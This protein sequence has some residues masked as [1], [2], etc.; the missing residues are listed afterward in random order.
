MKKSFFAI[1]LSSAL[2]VLCMG[3]RLSLQE[4][5]NIAL[6]NNL[7]IQI[8]KNDIVA[9]EMANHIG[10]AGGLPSVSITATDNQQLTS[11]NQELN[12]GQKISGNWSSGNTLNV[13]VTASQLLYNGMK[14]QTTKQ[15]LEEIEKLSREQF[16]ADVQNVVAEVMRQYY[17]VVMQQGFAKTLENS[18]STAR[19]RLE[20]VRTRKSVGVANN[21]D[22]YQTEIDVNNIK[23]QQ[24]QQVLLIQQTKSDLLKLL[25]LSSDSAIIISDT[26]VV[27]KHFDKSVVENAFL[28][29]YAV[30]AAQQQINISALIEK[31]VASLRMPS[32]R[33]NGGFNFGRSQS[34][35]QVLLNQTYGPFIGLSLSI[36]IYN[37][38]VYKRQQ[39]IA[40]IDTKNAYLQKSKI[41][42]EVQTAAVKA[43]NAYDNY[44]A[45]LTIEQ[46]NYKLADSL[47]YLI[48]QR[49]VLGYSNILEVKEAENSYINAGYRLVN[50]SYA[51]KT[52]EIELRRIM[53]D[54]NF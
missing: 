48:N 28:K 4:A 23:Q 50:L 35:G 20:I 19:Q 51:L 10:M 9:A 32:L 30:I 2:P 12:S 6:K 49:Y 3:Q 22:L 1:L 40:A 27:E 38:G 14:V 5:I 7:D 24:Q 36:P 53:N 41:E 47:L 29:N 8:S 54:L 34:A 16:N 37:G 46:G 15:R 13:G 33:L 43:L 25:N 42:N 21:V 44:L 45:Q 31:E 11:V 52:A 17:L 39:S 26:I 18:L